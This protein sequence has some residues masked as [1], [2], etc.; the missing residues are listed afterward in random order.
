MVEVDED[1]RWSCDICGY[2]NWARLSGFF[3]LGCK[4]QHQEPDHEFDDDEDDEDE[5]DG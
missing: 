5:F 4:W 1:G 2:P 3:C